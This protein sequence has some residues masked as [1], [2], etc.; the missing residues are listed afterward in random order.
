MIQNLNRMG[1]PHMHRAAMID[2]PCTEPASCRTASRLHP[3]Y[4]THSKRWCIKTQSRLIYSLFW[5][6]LFTACNQVPL[7]PLQ[8][9]FLSTP[10]KTGI[11]VNFCTDKAQ[12]VKSRLK[13]IIV[14][15]HSESNV[16][17]YIMD[18]NTG[19]PVLPF[20]ALPSLGTDPTG[21]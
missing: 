8:H 13:Y 6:C 1:G 3:F 19:G 11:T 4:S 9:I 10:A 5:C 18:P 12:V 2:T 16:L 17:N 20:T 14:I 21:F 15:D 7:S